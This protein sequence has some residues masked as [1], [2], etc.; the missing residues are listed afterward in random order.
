[1]SEICKYIFSVASLSEAATYQLNHPPPAILRAHP[2]LLSYYVYSSEI[3]TDDWN[4][5]VVKLSS[6]TEQP[7][8]KAVPSFVALG[9]G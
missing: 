5:K 6:N 1:M 7:F 4:V 8:P 2:L 3:V 9:I